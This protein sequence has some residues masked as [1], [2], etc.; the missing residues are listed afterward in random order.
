[1]RAAIRLLVGSMRFRALVLTED[2]LNETSDLRRPIDKKS[3]ADQPAEELK[4]WG[5]TL[6]MTL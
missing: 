2:D 3:S 5:L 6:G 1:M 4:L